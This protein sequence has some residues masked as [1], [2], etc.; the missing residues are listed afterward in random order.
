MGYNLEF[1]LVKGLTH[2]VADRL[3]PY[4]KKEDKCLDLE[5]RIVPSV[6]SKSLRTKQSGE[7]PKDPHINKIASI[8]K[9]DEDYQYMI[10]AIRNKVPIKA[11][12]ESS[13]L[14][15]IQGQYDN[16]HSTTQVKETL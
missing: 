14:K 3:S 4:P 11:I 12:K 13:E 10:D 9:S 15:Q 5:D 6:A 2:S 7:N 1:V 16:F 8:A